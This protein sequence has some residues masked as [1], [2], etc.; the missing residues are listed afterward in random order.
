MRTGPKPLPFQLG[1]AS[2]ASAGMAG[3]AVFEQSTLQ[4]FFKGVQKYQTHPWRREIE[5][6]PIAWER[7]EARLYHAKA[8]GMVRHKTPVVLVPSMVN[9]SDILDLLP[10][11]SL[12]RWL[13]AQGF[14]AY[15]FDW[16]QPAEDAGQA[17]FDEALLQRLVPA[18]ESLEK[19]VLMLGY[20]MGGLF[21][22]A[23][24]TLR[25]DLVKGCLLL[26][27]PWNFHDAAGQLKAR[28]S[29]MQPMA[30]PYM[31]QYNRLPD[32]WMQA[33]FAT[34]DPEGS[35]RKFASFAVMKE[36]DPREHVFMAVEDWLNEG[37]DLPAGIAATCMEEWYG[38]NL[39][40]A[41][42]WIVGGKPVTAGAVRV[43]TFVVAAKDDKIVPVD[44]AMAFAEQRVKCE[45]FVANTGHVGLIAGRNA[46][47]EIWKQM[48]AWFAAVQP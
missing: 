5:A 25:P 26:A 19:P 36:G 21:T 4:N 13:A 34:L 12:L 39:P 35:I 46:I 32:S 45:R 31:K 14:E 2:L 30:V 9:K 10:D 47:E 44:A 7:G 8:G 23:A 1:M 33:V 18:I 40:M 16:G 6:L 11:R 43:P 38:D 24:A 29:L 37:V 28:L 17:G 22:V 27:T 41:G 48:A 15:L 20:C 42:E 3:G